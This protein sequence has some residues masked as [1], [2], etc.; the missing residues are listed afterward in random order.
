MYKFTSIKRQLLGNVLYRFVP[1]NQYSLQTLLN[2]K[3][4]FSNPH[5]Q[6]DPIDSRYEI[7]VSS[8]PLDYYKD[9]FSKD[10]PEIVTKRYLRVQIDIIIKNTYGI[11]CF[12]KKY[13]NILMWSHYTV[14]ATGFCLMFDKNK[15]YNSLKEQNDSM[16]I[17][18]V[19]YGRLPTVAPSLRDRKLQF[20]YRDIIN[21]KLKE[22]RYESEVRISCKLEKKYLSKPIRF[23]SFDP[24]SLKCII[25]GER[26]GWEER[27]SI[28]NILGLKEYKHVIMFKKVRDKNNPRSYK[29]KLHRG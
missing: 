19:K 25:M 22:W 17:D 1:F 5:Y 11:S 10:P 15:L 21:F 27:K 13:N 18:D 20:D 4:Y 9:S 6:N 7:D 12:S 8:F 3:L 29:Y 2:H 24:F 14:G 26:M 23:Y 16:E 28:C